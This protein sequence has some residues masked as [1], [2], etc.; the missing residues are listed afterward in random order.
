MTGS[1]LEETGGLPFL[2]KLLEEQQT[3]KT[4]PDSQQHQLPS[5]LQENVTTPTATTTG[6]KPLHQ[7]LSSSARK[8]DLTFPSRIQLPPI[9]CTD[10]TARIGILQLYDQ[11]NHIEESGAC[12]VSIQRSVNEQQTKSRPSLTQSSPLIPLDYVDA[13]F[14]RCVRVTFREIVCLT[15]EGTQLGN[16]ETPPTNEAKPGHVDHVVLT[17]RAYPSGRGLGGTVWHLSSDSYRASVLLCDKF[18]VKPNW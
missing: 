8:S 6:W 12:K 7:R 5:S 9:Y 16:D 14:E 1:S 17:L 2:L 18:T 10:A 13:A 3:G 11:L 15:R 4:E